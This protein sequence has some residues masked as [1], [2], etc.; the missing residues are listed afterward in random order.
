MDAQIS[1]TIAIAL[2]RALSTSTSG[3]AGPANRTGA[4]YAEANAA[5]V[6]TR[7]PAA[8][9]KPVDDARD[10]RAE[11]GGSDLIADP[12]G[13][14]AGT[15]GMVTFAR[16]HTQDLVEHPADRDTVL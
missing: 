16:T 2:A 1:T 4:T 5:W 11:L 10:A 6:G 12:E 3:S 13:F 8:N 15:L 9:V 14:V 7:M